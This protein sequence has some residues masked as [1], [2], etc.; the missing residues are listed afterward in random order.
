MLGRI[1][2]GFYL[3]RSSGRFSDVFGALGRAWVSSWGLPI[4]R[5]PRALEALSYSSPDPKRIEEQSGW[6][7][8]DCWGGW[9]PSTTP[10]LFKTPPFNLASFLVPLSAG[11]PT[12][13]ALPELRRPASGSWRVCRGAAAVAF[14]VGCGGSVGFVFWRWRS[15]EELPVLDCKALKTFSSFF[16]KGLR[17]MAGL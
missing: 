6:L 7:C 4:D 3:G 12:D 13:L 10:F 1:L 2:F 11:F 15:F 14:G 17:A 16:L 5:I 8:L 9:R